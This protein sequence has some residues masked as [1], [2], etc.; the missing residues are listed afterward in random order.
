MKSDFNAILPPNLSE[1]LVIRISDSQYSYQASR[2]FVLNQTEFILMNMNKLPIHAV[3]DNQDPILL[4]GVNPENVL[5]EPDEEESGEP[6]ILPE[7]L[8]AVSNK[9]RGIPQAALLGDFIT[10]RNQSEAMFGDKQTY[11]ARNKMVPPI[12]QLDSTRC[13]GSAAAYW[14]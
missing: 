13:G 2:D 6:G 9:A 5:E 14:L 7:A 8:Q 12:A 4:S 3:V 1:Q 10:N 11:K